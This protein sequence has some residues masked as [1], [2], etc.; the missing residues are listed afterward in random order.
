MPGAQKAADY[1]YFYKRILR[2]RIYLL[3][4]LN[5]LVGNFLPMKFKI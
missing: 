2:I 3:Q 4:I 5:P 1:Q